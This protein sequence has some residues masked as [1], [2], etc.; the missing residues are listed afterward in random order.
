MEKRCIHRPCHAHTS[1]SK[2]GMEYFGFAPKSAP[3]APAVD[4]NG[5]AGADSAVAANM[6]APFGGATEAT[7]AWETGTPFSALLY[8]STLADPLD[9]A[10]EVKPTVVWD[11]LT[12]G[13]WKEVRE[14]D[15]VLD[16][17]DSVRAHNGS[18]YVDILL[19]KG[20]GDSPAGKDGADVAHHRK[21]EY[22][23]ALGSANSARTHPLDAE[24][25]RA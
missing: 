25:P 6:S 24:A 1:V 11:G 21:G 4:V 2:Y 16:V 20:G 12:F 13:G 5:T 15:L 23:V 9:V 22:N 8:F 14:E 18:W 10:S 19:I 7:S 3:A 17:P